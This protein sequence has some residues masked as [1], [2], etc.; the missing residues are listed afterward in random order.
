MQKIGTVLLL[1]LSHVA[2]LSQVEHSSHLFKTLQ[3]KDSLLFEVGFNT[4]DI[5]QFED[6]VSENFEFYHD[7]SGMTLSKKAF[8][9]SIRDGLCKLPYRPKR[10]LVEHSLEVY[11]LERDGVVYGAIQTGRHRFYA[12]EKDK[13][14]YLTSTAQFTHVWLLENTNWKLSRGFSYDHREPAPV[15]T[16]DE[17]MLFSNRA[18][19]EQWLAEHRIPALGIGYIRNGKIQEVTVYGQNDKGVPYPDNTIFNVASLTKPVTALV[20]LKLVETGQWSLDEPVARYWTDPDIADDLRSRELTTR[21]ILSHQT[22]FPNWRYQTS[23]GQLVFT[24]DPGTQYQYSGEGFEYLRKALENKFG[25]PL[26]Q[27][28]RELILQP[29]GMTDTRFFWDD[30]VDEA[31]FARWYRADGTSYETEKNTSANGADN[32][33][34]TVGDYSRF[35]LHILNGAGLSRT[36]YRDMVSRQVQVQS[37]KYFGLGWWVDEN[38]DNGGNVLVH[39]GDDIGVHTIAFLL[40]ESRTGLVIF[41]N[42]DNGTD[43]YIPVIQHYLGKTGQEIIEVE[44]R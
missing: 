4:C 11:P 20:A 16:T 28:A 19:T 9:G 13:P 32:L 43:V 18:R 30:T 5:R 22:G 2:A 42:C 29:L 14:A 27:L 41:T 15:D 23:T 33:L 1:L 37:R 34:T 44:T 3:S 40:P 24:F 38:V 17:G 10:E 25:K 36:L 31:R 12:F 39:G 26:D 21:H 7:K 6:L 8:I 35:M